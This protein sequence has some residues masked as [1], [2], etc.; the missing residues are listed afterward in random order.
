MVVIQK[1][2]L[3]TLNLPRVDLIKIDI[4]GMEM[5]ALEGAREMIER[6]SPVLLIESIKADRETIR[7]WLQ[8]RGYRAIEAGINLLAIHLGDPVLTVLN[9]AEPAAA[10]SAA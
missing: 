6:S 1:M 8:D 2:K 3:D 5:E 9:P 10:S 4:E 7:T